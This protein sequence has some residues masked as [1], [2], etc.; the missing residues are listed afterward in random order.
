MT[1][2]MDSPA[3]FLLLAVSIVVIAVAVGGLL[4]K[5]AEAVAAIELAISDPKRGANGFG[6]TESQRAETPVRH[7]THETPQ[8]V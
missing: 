7:E 8:A 1:I 2:A 3:V 6:S 5:A 4:D